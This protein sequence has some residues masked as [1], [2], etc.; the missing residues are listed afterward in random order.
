MLATGNVGAVPGEELGDD[1]RLAGVKIIS[2]EP[3]LDQCWNGAATRR[4]RCK[5]TGTG[6]GTGTHGDHGR[7]TLRGMSGG[8][9]V[10]IQEL[11]AM[12][13]PCR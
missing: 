1:R 4:G 2:V 13:P 5:A 11:G 6:G 7:K 9:P 12:L 8:A 3:F 10:K